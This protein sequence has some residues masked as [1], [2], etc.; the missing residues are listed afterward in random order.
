MAALPAIVAGTGCYQYQDSPTDAVRPGQVVHVTL[1][2]AAAAALASAIGPNAASVDGRVLSRA[3]ADVTIAV[4]QIA[5]TEGPEQFLQNEPLTFSL[6]GA[7]ALG[8]RSWD[9]GRTL[10][11]AG[12]IVAAVVAGQIF[13]DQSG[14]FAPKGGV[15]SSTK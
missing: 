7:S 11:A 6:A 10:L 2:P 8:V 5:R 12:G 14:I 4:T 9:K 1:T 15:S 3:G 13:I